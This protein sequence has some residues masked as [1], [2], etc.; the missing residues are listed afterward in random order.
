M[1]QQLVWADLAEDSEEE[2]RLEEEIAA[3]AVAQAQQQAEQQQLQQAGD[4]ELRF[5]LG[6]GHALGLRALCLWEAGECTL[7]ALAAA[8]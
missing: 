7:T 5:H 8:L 4:G 1:Y 3:A 2:E 6:V